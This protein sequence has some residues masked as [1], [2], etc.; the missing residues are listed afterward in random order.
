MAGCLLR[1][2]REPQLISGNQRGGRLS[3]EQ[4]EKGQF[5]AIVRGPDK[6]LKRDSLAVISADSVL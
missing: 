1:M 2:N 3:A 4:R 6:L 5:T